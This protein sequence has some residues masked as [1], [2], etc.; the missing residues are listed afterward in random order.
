MV[1]A[2]G[3]IRIITEHGGGLDSDGEPRRVECTEGD[4]IPCNYKRNSYQGRVTENGSSHSV[5][6][7]Q[8]V[9]GI[10]PFKPCRFSLYDNNG[11]RLG[12]YEVAVRGIE[13]LEFVGNTRLT[14]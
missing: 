3:Y 8:I 12:T 2:N 6:S 4:R 13:P 9:I 14:V 7:Y 11:E 1:L 5:A 10:C